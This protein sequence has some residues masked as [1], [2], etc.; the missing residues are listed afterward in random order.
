MEQHCSRAGEE[1]M[2]LIVKHVHALRLH[3][4]SV[5]EEKE[6][7]IHDMRVA[8][9]RLRAG[10]KEFAFLF[11]TGPRKRFLEP[12]RA[13]TQSLG[14]PRELDVTLGLVANWSS[15]LGEGPRE[16][17]RG[18]QRWL[19]AQRADSAG[20]C[21]EAV[22]HIERPAFEESL[23]ALFESYRPTLDC[24]LE[25]G[26]GNLG[27]QLTKL[28]KRYGRWLDELS[29]NR[30]HEVRI[31]FKKLRY[32]SE[33]YAPAYGRGMKDFIKRLKEAQEALGKWNDERT[34]GEYLIQVQ[35]QAGPSASDGLSFF[36][37][38]VARRTAGL[39]NQFKSSAGRFF[40]PSEQESMSAL[41][42][43]PV[44]ACCRG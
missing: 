22:S 26:A 28:S 5:R 24:H 12:V 16:G 2:R 7:G 40:S 34:L 35:E 29:E 10:L 25:T 41:L 27:K 38:E 23:T 11:E 4:D 18:V 43:H 15:H 20:S 19:E 36:S 42:A 14:R 31:L 30:L 21:R 17:I 9:R 32:A 37:E 1:A 8:S 44:Q 39:L 3:L 6:E 13:V 33:L